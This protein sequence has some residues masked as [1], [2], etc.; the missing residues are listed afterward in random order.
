MLPDVVHDVFTKKLRGRLDRIHSAPPH[1][2]CHLHIGARERPVLVTFGEESRFVLSV[3][4]RE[5]VDPIAHQRLDEIDITG[6][7]GDTYWIDDTMLKL[8]YEFEATRVPPQGIE[9]DLL[10]FVRSA[11]FEVR[12]LE[13]LV[14]FRSMADMPLPCTRH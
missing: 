7:W 6:M 14:D 10:F 2:L 1:L 5:E 9:E 12:I 8:V 11:E 3:M 4:V 13:N